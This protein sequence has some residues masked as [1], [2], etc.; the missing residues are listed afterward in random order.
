[1]RRWFLP[2]TVIGLGGVGALLMSERGRGK[3]RDL[4]QRFQDSPDGWQGLNDNVQSELDRIQ[5]SLDRISES[6]DPRPQM[7][8]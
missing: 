3:L 8:R 5:A 4:W 7:G 6:I 2:L 1:M